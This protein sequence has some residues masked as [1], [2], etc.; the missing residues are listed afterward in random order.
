MSSN[1]PAN[2]RTTPDNTL[3]TAE[4]IEYFRR[5]LIAWQAELSDES[6]RI[7]S[8]LEVTP[9]AQ[10]IPMERAANQ[11]EQIVRFS[12][13]SNKN[14][15]MHKIKNVLRRIEEGKYGFYNTDKLWY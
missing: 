2:D 15:I 3:I 13:K 14:K 9:A 7:L 5:R 8:G 10:L 1:I 4:Q 11:P 6:E 12:P